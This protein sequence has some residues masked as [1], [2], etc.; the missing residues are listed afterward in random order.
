[1]DI[2]ENLCFIDVTA[3]DKARASRHEQPGYYGTACKDGTG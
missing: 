2:A 1:M 3:E